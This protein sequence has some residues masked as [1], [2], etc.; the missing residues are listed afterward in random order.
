MPEVRWRYQKLSPEQEEA[1]CR[2]LMDGVSAPV[3]ALQYGVNRRTIYRAAHRSLWRL[4]PVEI[5]GWR[6]RFRLE[7]DG[8]IQME[9]WRLA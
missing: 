9:P 2:A 7:D 4:Y 8:P 3:L 5:E 1:V 6:A